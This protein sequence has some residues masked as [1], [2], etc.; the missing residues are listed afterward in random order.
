MSVHIQPGSRSGEAPLSLQQEHVWKQHE[1]AEDQGALNFAMALRI[2]GDVCPD[3][4]EA[5]LNALIAQHEILRASFHVA[6]GNIRQ[7]IE[8]RAEVVLPVPV[9]VSDLPPDEQHEELAWLMVEA[10]SEPFDL[11]YAPLMRARIFRLGSDEALLLMVFHR[12]VADEL[13]VPA[14]HEAFTANYA[15]PDSAAAGRSASSPSYVGYAHDQRA[16]PPQGGEGYRAYWETLANSRRNVLKL[17][18]DR[19]RSQEDTPYGA[20]HMRAISES[21]RNRMRALTRREEVPCEALLFAAYQILLHMHSGEKDLLVRTCGWGGR[22]DPEGVRIGPFN[23][24]ATAC[25]SIDPDALVMQALHH[26]SRALRSALDHPFPPLDQGAEG[27]MR[28]DFLGQIRV[29]F[30]FLEDRDG[31]SSPPPAP[32]KAMLVD[33]GYA[34]YDWSLLAHQRDEDLLIYLNYRTDLFDPTTI[35][36]A[37]DQ[38][39]IILSRICDAPGDTLAD[40]IAHVRTSLPGRGGGRETS[41]SSSNLEVRVFSRRD[42]EDT[43][44]GRFRRLVERNPARIAI[45]AGAQAV[46]YEQVDAGS[47]RL[48]RA[49][50]RRTGAPRGRIALLCGQGADMPMALLGSLKAGH[51]YVPLDPASPDHRLQQIVQDS[52]SCMVMADAAHVERARALAPSLPVMDITGTINGDEDGPSLPEE[53][54]DPHQPAYIIYTSG[55]TGKPKGVVQNHRNVLHFIACYTNAI[56]IHERDRMSLFTSYCFDAAVMDIYGALL[57]GATLY[58][59]DMKQETFHEVALR[60]Q[61]ERITLYHSTPTVYRYLMDSLDPDT[62]FDHVRLVVLGGEAVR[63]RDLDL[64]RKHF[65]PRA[66]FVNLFGST[67][68]SVS[69]IHVMD[70]AACRSADNVPVGYPV[71]HTETILLDEDGKRAHMEGEIGIVSDHAAPEYWRDPERTAAT[72]VVDPATGKRI[73]RS[74]D[75]GRLLPDGRMIFLGRKDYQVKIRGFRIELGEIESVLASH[76]AVAQCVLMAER[77]RMDEHALSAFMVMRS[78]TAA[79]SDAELKTY[80]AQRLPSY[81]IPDTMV[82]ME[83]MPLTPNGKIDRMALKAKL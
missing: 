28:P 38:Y 17:W 69:A 82:R 25:S 58:P 2:S 52:E 11:A 40:L 50:L 10:C 81:M 15:E 77:N 5:S 49:I 44:V 30:T 4:M 59:F 19:A 51:A 73:Y 27:K 43:I 45:Q 7:C 78:P 71:E 26:S 8:S 46:T 48:G 62:V 23:A 36:Q 54:P 35:A 75:Q 67:E 83:A 14:I 79:C 63:G 57:N 39:E 13:S 6:G 53:E 64:F 42:V 16:T 68:S 72:F 29:A 18:S 61:A 66:S 32:I 37:L 47:D 21:L 31:A 34:R 76:P 56:G 20:R 3:R 41:G 1:R 9:D 70:H 12:L 55:S 22:H 74:G 60:L 24:D 65:S 80:L 33:D